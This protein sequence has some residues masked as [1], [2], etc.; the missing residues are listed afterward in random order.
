M[1]RT[2]QAAKAELLPSQQPTSKH[3]S[4]TID[5]IIQAAEARQ[6]SSRVVSAPEAASEQQRQCSSD[7]G[8]SLSASP[9][10]PLTGNELSKLGFALVSPERADLLSLPALSPEI[11]V[12]SSASVEDEAAAELGESLAALC[13]LLEQH[14]L[15][16]SQSSFVEK[17]VGMLNEEQ[18]NAA[19]A[20]DSVSLS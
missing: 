9:H 19:A 3:L 10:G 15:I 18:P 8:S 17:T 11:G 12:S 20:V 14:V 6:L 1:S 4:E 7:S 13:P 16:A 5:A 2:K